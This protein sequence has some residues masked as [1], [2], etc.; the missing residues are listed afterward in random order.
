MPV[1]I[2]R[3]A[4]KPAVFYRTLFLDGAL[5]DCGATFFILETTD[6]IGA[7]AGLAIHVCPA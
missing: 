7:V 1:R 2:R 5:V 3:N 4:V 6:V